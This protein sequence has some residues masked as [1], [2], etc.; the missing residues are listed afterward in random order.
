MYKDKKIAVS[1]PCYNESKFIKNVI[2]NIPDYV[3]FIITVDDCS[4]DDT[5]KVL[6]SI[7]SKKL[8]VLQTE[9]NVGVGGASKVGFLKAI[10][11]EA[12]IV[13]KVDGDGQMPLVTLPVFLDV[14]IDQKIDYAKGNRFI[15]AVSLKNM[16]KHRLIANIILTFL[17]KLGSGY[18]NIFDPQNGFLAI[19]TEKVKFFDFLKVHNRY[20]FENDMLLQAN[21]YNL[22]VQDIPL[23]T[24]YGN[25][26]SHINTLQVFFTFPFLFMRM[27]FYRIYQKYVLRD[28]SPIILFLF[29]GGILFWFGLIFGLYHW[30]QSIVTNTYASTG[31]VMIATVCFILGFQLLLQAIVLDINNTPKK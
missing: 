3:D 4:K 27:F 24:I 5:Y 28:F 11:L 26:I 23:E 17:N 1:I 10:E 19:K 9:K 16:P 8:T 25:E 6:Q 15:D 31:T 14:I 22:K 30:I 12:D 7:K 2:K 21:I 13:V 20:F 29:F 18:W